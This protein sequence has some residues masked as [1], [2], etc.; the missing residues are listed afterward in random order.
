[1]PGEQLP[2]LPP[3][4]HLAARGKWPLVGEKLPRSS[5]EPWTVTLDG[6]VARGVVWSLE[7]LRKL[8]QVERII[9]IHCVTR[10]SMPGARFGG[11][12]LSVLLDLARPL[13]AA[14]F[15][16]FVARSER[17]HSTSLPLQTALELNALVALNWEGKPIETAHGGPV[18]V[19]V[20]ERYFYKSL[21]WLERIELLAEDRLGY[22]EG[23][24]GYHNEADPWKEQRYVAA[25][26]DPRVVRQLLAGRNISGHS[27]MG[28]SAERTDLS[29]LDARGSLLRNA[30]FRHAGLE[31]ARF[32]GANLSNAHLEFADLR[33]ASFGSYAGKAADVEGAS[34][35]GADLRGTDLAGASLFG[36]TFWDGVSGDLPAARIDSTTRIDAAGIEQLAPLQRE[37]LEAALLGRPV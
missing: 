23:E 4:Q 36:A 20:P 2:H 19:I 7:E 29:G 9:D 6:L 1:M 10:W 8:P 35:Q 5:N 24:A 14:S 28:L 17:N 30:D 15:V 34:F 11:V 31:S 12:P 27:L 33:N 21:K 16:N 25:G 3:R 22:W 37:F 13:P 32:D 18:R 26:L